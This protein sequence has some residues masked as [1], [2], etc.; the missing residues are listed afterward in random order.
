LYL[1]AFNNCLYDLSIKDFR[2]IQPTDYICKTTGY[3]IKKTSDPIIRNELENILA[4]I[5]N[6]KKNIDYYKKVISQI[7]KVNQENFDY[8]LK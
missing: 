8:I 6:D 3:A 2:D 1:I 5:F 4:Q 7:H